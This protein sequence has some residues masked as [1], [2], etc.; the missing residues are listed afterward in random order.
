MKSTREKKPIN[1]LAEYLTAWT[2]SNTR[3]FAPYSSF[4]TLL[5]TKVEQKDVERWVLNCNYLY[6]RLGDYLFEN[7]L[8]PDME[9][10]LASLFSFL[11]EHVKTIKDTNPLNL[12]SK[13]NEAVAREFSRDWPP[14][15]QG[16]RNRC[17]QLDAELEALATFLPDG[18]HARSAVES[19]AS[20]MQRE[21]E[22]YEGLVGGE[23]GDKEAVANGSLENHGYVERYRMLLALWCVKEVNPLYSLLIWEDASAVRELA[24][25]L[26]DAFE[27]CGFRAPDGSLRHGYFIDVV[28]R[29]LEGYLASLEL[30]D[31]SEDLRDLD[32]P[33]IHDLLEREFFQI[34]ALETS[35]VLPPWLASKCRLIWNVVVCAVIGPEHVI[36]E[37]RTIRT[38]TVSVN[39]PSSSS[40]G[41]LQGEVL[42]R[43]HYRDGSV[44]TVDRIDLDE[45]GEDLLWKVIGSRYDKNVSVPASRFAESYADLGSRFLST[46]LPDAGSG[47]PAGSEG[48]GDSRYH[49]ELSVEVDDVGSKRLTL[50]D[51]GSKNGTFVVR[52]SDGIVGDAKGAVNRHC[53]ALESRKRYAPGELSRKLSIPEEAVSYVDEVVLGRGDLIYLCG[54]CFEIA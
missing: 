53:F 46:R 28:N 15:V 25:H 11:D 42:L 1:V 54:S 44:Q 29:S 24:G 7:G 13:Q 10:G 4:E 19:F 2:K 6:Y 39:P 20:E 3:D 35:S 26:A 12:R 33:S 49:A 18:Q 36:G 14:L 37:P 17:A 48:E 41:G 38:E 5:E 31:R 51:L 22:F 23:A 47:S 8:L 40:E 45:V 21:A 43:R 32:I 52:E 16:S 27:S 9:E 34:D 30:E 50:R